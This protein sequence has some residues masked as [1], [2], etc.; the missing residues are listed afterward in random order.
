MHA[1]RELREFWQILF[2]HELPTK[3]HHFEVRQIGAD[4]MRKRWKTVIQVQQ[5]TSSPALLVASLKHVSL[6][7]APSLFTAA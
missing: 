1:R 5:Y 7:R 6:R 2:E 4:A 3:Y